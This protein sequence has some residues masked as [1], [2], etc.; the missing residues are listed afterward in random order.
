MVPTDENNP[1]LVSHKNYQDPH[2]GGYGKTMAPQ[3]NNR[4][5]LRDINSNIVAPFYRPALLQKSST[6]PR[7]DGM[8]EKKPPVPVNRPL[9][10]RYA[11]QLNNKPHS[12]KE[13]NS[14]ASNKS[15]LTPSEP[16]VCIH[17]D[18]DDYM[19]DDNMPLPSFVQHTEAMLKEID[20]MVNE[21]EMDD[22]PEELIQDIDGCD[23][24]NPL[25][26]VEYV[27]DIYSYYRR[28]EA[29]SCALSNYMDQQ[30]DINGK[31]RG[32]LIDWLIEVHYKFELMEETL[33][34][35]INL[36]DRFLARQVVARKK[37]QLV[38]VTAMLIACKYEEVS[39]PVVEDFI[40]ISD[41]A[42]TREDVLQMERLMVNTLHF[43]L[44]APTSY[45]FMQRFLKAAESNKKLELLSFFII[46]LCLVEY[47]MLRFPPSL[48]SAAAIFTAQ[49]SIGGYMKW[50]ATC[51]RHSGYS[52]FQ[53]LE[54]ARLMVTLHQNA[55]TGKLTGVHRKY[56]T[57]KYG[58]AANSV[59][60]SFLLEARY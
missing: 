13:E 3:V 33:Y 54:C 26:V 48:L 52:Q 56:N 17:K 6:G 9:T 31:M 57:S 43:N 15:M 30:S 51:E 38:G 27:E 53:L 11:S 1:I 24:D 10:R 50:T 40:V 58:Y 19:V 59:P 4:P 49:C 7:N 23:K 46:E 32:I 47:E 44:S 28:V 41:R 2:A 16:Q 14:N 42:Y 12:A 35:T 34:L 20:Q 55:G 60:A 37:L 25:A 29:A 22:M 45:V 39:V 18:V 36:I 5:A 21:V 8:L